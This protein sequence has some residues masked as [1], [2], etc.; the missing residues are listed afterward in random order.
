MSV[1]YRVEHKLSAVKDEVRWNRSV[2]NGLEYQLSA[3]N[4]D[5]R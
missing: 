2:E 3:A 5:V 4:D 1:E